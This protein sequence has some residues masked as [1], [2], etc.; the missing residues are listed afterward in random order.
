MRYGVHRN[1]GITFVWLRI[2]RVSNE[3]VLIAKKSADY[4]LEIR[5]TPDGRLNIIPHSG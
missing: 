3:V 2:L 1:Q 4:S 5:D